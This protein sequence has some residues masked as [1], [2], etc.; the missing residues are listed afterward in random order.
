MQSASLQSTS[1]ST[2]LSARQAG[3]QSAKLSARQPAS[4][5]SCQP[6]SQEQSDIMSGPPVSMSESRSEIDTR[7]LN[8]T[9]DQT[10][11]G[12][13]DGE[14]VGGGG[15]GGRRREGVEV[16]RS[17]RR[18]DASRGGNVCKFI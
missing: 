15:G 11:M 14:S 7:L 9:L 4:Q 5:P 6:R 2:K 12:G 10:G 3:S 8:S 1:Q 17:D 16:E 13:R 18:E